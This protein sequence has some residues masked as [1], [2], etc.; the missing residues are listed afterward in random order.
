VSEDD[1]VRGAA[2]AVALTAIVG[3]L[4]WMLLSPTTWA[5]YGLVVAGVAV[6]VLLWRRG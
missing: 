3:G 6:M 1:F 4:I 5:A 2:S